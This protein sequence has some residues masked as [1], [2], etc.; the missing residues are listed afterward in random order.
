MDNEFEFH[1][2]PPSQSERIN[3]AYQ[4]THFESPVLSAL[5]AM[6]HPMAEKGWKLVSLI[7]ANYCYYAVMENIYWIDE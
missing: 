2:D 1:L 7:H 6:I 3:L 5:M 4:Y